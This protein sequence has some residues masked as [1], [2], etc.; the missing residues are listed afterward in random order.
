MVL[1]TEIELRHGDVHC[2]PRRTLLVLH[3]LIHSKSFQ[4]VKCL[5]GI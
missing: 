3:N 4:T 5:E 2:L 1:G